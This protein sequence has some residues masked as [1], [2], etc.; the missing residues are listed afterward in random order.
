MNN[1]IIKEKI[2]DLFRSSKCKVGQMVPMRTINNVFL[3]QQVDYA[4][5]IEELERDELVE[6]KDGSLPGLFLTKKGYDLIYVS[7]PDSQLKQKVLD[8]FIS[9]NCK[10]GQG[11]MYRTLDNAVISNLNP[12]DRERIFI[13]LDKMI[14]DEEISVSFENDYP[15]FVKLTEK[16]YKLIH[17]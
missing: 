1:E 6:Y 17:P 4:P 2:F 8:I 7:T 3:R 13:V 14:D 9:T 16:G 12:K 10:V 15:V 5:A 11:Y